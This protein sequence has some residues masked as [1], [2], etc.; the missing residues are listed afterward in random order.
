M[1]AVG[2]DLLILQLPIR[3]GFTKDFWPLLE[4]SR[5]PRCSSSQMR[6]RCIQQ[7]GP[8]LKFA[9]RPELCPVVSSK[10][11]ATDPTP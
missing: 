9:I 11:S 2:F 10:G 6:P 7:L 1:R 4:R 8:R 3:D 5:F